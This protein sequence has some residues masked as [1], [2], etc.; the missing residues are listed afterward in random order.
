MKKRVLLA[1]LSH[2]TNTFVRGLTSLADFRILP[3]EEMRQA[4]GDAS[5]LA[6]LLE[7]AR[8][9]DWEVI[10]VVHMGATPGPTVADEVIGTFWKTFEAAA[11]RA[12][13]QGVDGILLDMHG[14][15]VSQSLPDVEGELLRRIRRLPGLAD[16]PLC[17]VLDLHGNFT[18]AM[19]Q[20]S[21]GLV[22]YRQ[23]PHA[24]SRQTAVEAARL[25]DRLLHTGER[26]AMVWEHPPIVWPPTGTGTADEPMRS[27]EARA[28]EIEAAHPEILAVNVFGGF[29]FAD[30][31][32]AGLSFSAVTLGAPEATHSLLK[33][34]SAL[35]LER[36]EQGNR[37]GMPLEEAMQRLGRH[38]EGPVLLV[39]P[40]DNIGG[41]A[42]G[43]CTPVLRAL[44]EHNVQNAAVCIN[45]PETVQ[46]LW[47]LAPGERKRVAVGGK[48][49]EIGATE[50]VR[51]EVEMVSKSD[52]RYTLEDPHSHAA[53]SGRHQEMGPCVVVRHAGLRLLLTSR[54]TPPFDL[55]QWRSQGIHPEALFVI[56][57]KAAVAHRQAYNKIAKA[58]YTLDT[59]GPCAENLRR[60]PYQ[61]I[62]RPIYPLDELP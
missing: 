42:P 19:A 7:V 36:K 44:L 20:H 40:A 37:M 11:A 32:E 59:P 33:E 3:G 21:N 53:G 22:A 18:A 50:P 60:L 46:A 30:I 25:L 17:G 2:E 62:Q 15:M 57:V 38:R 13:P 24:D 54:K 6:G 26:P 23:N 43:D 45:D 34:L 61:H 28:R 56:G 8:E 27:L 14:A 58:S 39:E 10:P 35:A 41:G 16:V 51:L 5:T 49:G 55:G 4:E 31:P 29:S 9:R 48:S 47:N 1:G 52:G 12:I